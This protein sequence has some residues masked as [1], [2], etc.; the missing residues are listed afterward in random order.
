MNLLRDIQKDAIDNNASLESLLRKCRVLASRLKN[1]EL[2]LWSQ[3]ELDGYFGDEDVPVYRQIVGQ[4]CGHFSGPFGSGIRNAPIADS[5]IPKKI[6]DQL[7]RIR[8]RESV[9]AIEHLLSSSTDKTLQYEWPG[10]AARIFGAEIYENQ[11]LVQ[12]WT[13]VPLSFC[14]GILS[15]VRNR[16]LNFAL[17]I[18]AQNPDAGEAEPNSTPIPADQVSQIVHNYI[19]GNV[20][21]FA[22]GQNFQQSSTAIISQGDLQAL[23]S[24][25]EQHGVS[26]S[27]LTAMKS[28]L[29]RE[30]E[31]KG[32]I[33][34][35]RVATWIGKMVAKAAE[36]TWKIGTNVAAT[37]LT[38]Y[39][40]QYYG[41]P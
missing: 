40:K 35:P 23:E 26:K 8:M 34:G 6:R 18:E 2:K 9:A 29:A 22:S 10:D 15:T 1:D 36:G 38:A 4:G 21:N 3:R 41:L 28:A 33:F 12:G 7:I 37:L 24:A 32:E 25:L 17:E 20:G 14:A 19:Y 31:P 13:K 39:L 27:D 5:L 16:I 30:P 11:I